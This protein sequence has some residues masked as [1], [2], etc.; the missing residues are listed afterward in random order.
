MFT[1]NIKSFTAASRALKF[2]QKNGIRCTLE[3]SFGREGDTMSRIPRPKAQQDAAPPSAGG[4]GFSLKIIDNN[5]NKA[6]V[7]AL[8]SSIGVPCDIP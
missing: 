3:R 8:L 7:C 6:E 4:C 5:T 1:V 2:L